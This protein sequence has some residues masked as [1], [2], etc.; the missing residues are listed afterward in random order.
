MIQD[1]VDRKDGEKVLTRLHTLGFIQ[2]EY[3]I[4]VKR[5]QFLEKRGFIVTVG[6]LDQRIRNPFPVYL[7]HFEQAVRDKNL[8]PEWHTHTHRI[9]ENPLIILL[10]DKPLYCQPEAKHGAAYNLVQNIIWIRYTHNEGFN[11][12]DKFNLYHEL[13]HWVQKTCFPEDMKLADMEAH[14]DRIAK[15]LL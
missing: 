4:D 13:T 10:T 3:P 5:M 8:I 6:D 15:Q 7:Q 14:A 2:I 12:A 1:L 11:P 9:L